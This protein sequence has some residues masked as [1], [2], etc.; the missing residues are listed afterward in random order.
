MS[1]APECLDNI[2]GL[3]ETTCECFPNKPADESKSGLW[4]DQ[5]E[6]LDLK[7]V[8]SI[9]DCEEGE[10]WDIMEKSRTNAIKTFRDDLM[11]GLNTKYKKKRHPFNGVIGSEKVTKTLDLNTDYAALRV[12][13]ANIISGVMSVKRIGLFFN[14]DVTFNISV[15]DGIHDEAIATYSVTAQAN[16]LS[17][18]NLAAPLNLDMTYEAYNENPNYYFMYEVNG[19][20]PKDVRAGCGCSGSVY[21]YYWNTKNPIYKSYEKDRWSEYVM[22]TGT[23]GNDLS[24]R[25]NW[26]T[27]QYMNGIILD[28]EFK[29]KV[30][31]LICKQELD[32]EYNEL[33]RTMAYAVRYKA[34]EILIDKILA[35]PHPN[36]Y[37]MTDRERLMGKKNTYVKNYIE[38]LNYLIE[39][40]NW[41]ANDCLTCND[42]DDI[43]KV[44]ILS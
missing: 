20:R 29:C 37:T 1:L 15:F 27:H 22:L 31:D 6:G 38:R 40:I 43:L 25:E 2:I 32:F 33:A 13:C 11:I 34:G 26:A 9:N 19:F 30:S 5:L 23:Q 42:F 12:W 14:Q 44:G 24:D 7:V 39:N 3:S 18:Y 8:D 16:K 10:L 41:K 28:A 17:W 21:K 35:S 4:L 36:V